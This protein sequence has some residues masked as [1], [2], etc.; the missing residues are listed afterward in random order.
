MQF[1]NCNVVNR[2]GVEMKCGDSYVYRGVVERIKS[3]FHFCGWV[4]N[5][6][7]NKKFINR[8]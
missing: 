6:I 5:G 7:L 8:L 2:V 1:C 4:Y 3:G